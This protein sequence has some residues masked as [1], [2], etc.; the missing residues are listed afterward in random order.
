MS[1]D[2]KALL[3]AQNDFHGRMSRSV[4]NLRKMGVS[5]ITAEAVQARL[6]ILDTLWTKFEAHHDLIRTTLKDKYLES[7]YA[8]ADFIDIAES[9]YVSQRSILVE[10][11]NSL[12]DEASITPKTERQ[13]Q[14]LKTSLPR[15]KLQSFSGA[16]GD[17]PAFR[18]I[19][20]S[21]VGSNASISDVEKLHYLRTSLQGPAEKLIRSLP[22]VGGNYER[23]WSILSSHYENKRELIRANFA[24]F[25]A[26]AKMKAATAD[27]L[28]RVYNAATTAINAQESIARPIDT[29]GMDLFNYLLIERFDAQTRMQ[30][31][32]SIRDSVDPPS[33]DVL[34]DFIAK[35]ILTLNAVQPATVAKSGEASRSAK[36]HFV[37]R[38]SDSSVCAVC[39]E[40]HSVM[41]CATFKA[42]TATERKTLVEA[43]KLCFNCLGNHFLAKCQST[44]TCFTCKARHHT[45]LHDAYSQADGAA[46]LSATHFASDRKAILLATARVTIKDHLGRPHDVRALIDQGS[47]VSLV[48]EALAQRLRLPRDR[49]S[50]K[51]AGIGG[52]TGATR[53]R[54]SMTL[55]SPITGAAFPPIHNTLTEI[56]IL[57]GADAYSAIL[58]D[59]LRKGRKDEPIAQRT[60][61]GWI[62]SGGHR[63]TKQAGHTAHQCTVDHELNDLVKL[64]WEQE[65][66]PVAP[67]AL[68]PEEKRCEDIFAREHSRTNAGRYMV[69]LPFAG[70][71]PSL[72][73]TRRPAERLLHAMER[74]C[75]KDA[76][77]GNLYR[78]FM[79]DYEDLQHMEAVTSSSQREDTA[80]CYLPHHGVLRET[81]T[82][83][84]LRV[85]FNGSQLTTLGTSLNAS[86]LTGANL[87]PA[88][89]DVLLRWRWH[90]YVFVADIEKMYRQILIHQDDR[91]HQRILWR[92]SAADDIREYRLRTVTYGLACAP[93]LAIRTLHQL[94]DDEGTRFPRGAAAL[95]RDTYVDDIVTGAG[96]LSEATLAQRELR[97]LCMAGGFPLRK[98]ATNDLR[99]LD[100]VPHEHRLTHSPHSWFHESHTTLGLHWHPAGDHFTFSQQARHFDELTKRRVLSETARMFDPLGWLTPVTMRAK[101]LIQS[102]WL[103]KLD[104][105]APLPSTDALAWK[106]LLTQLPRLN[107][108]RVSRW[109][110][111]DGSHSHVDLHGFA[112]ASE[113]GY[114]A[115][116]YLRS[117]TQKGT[118]IHLLNAKGKVA[119][120]KPVSLPRLELCAAALL[121]NL[122]AHTR[123]LLSLSAAPVFLWSDSKVTLHWIHGHASRWKTYVAN[124][125][126]LIQEQLPEARWRHVP[127]RDNPADCAS[128]GI[129]PDDL[130]DHLLWWTGPSWL[131]EDEARWPSDDG[132][133]LDADLPERR[134]VASLAAAVKDV[135]ESAF[136]LRFS[137]LHRLL[138]VTAWC[139]RWRR[140]DTRRPRGTTD[141]ARSLEACEIETALTRW[142]HTTQALHFH[143]EFNAL[144]KERALPPRSP[145]TSLNPFIDDSGVMRVGGRLK[146]AML[147]HDE[148]HPIIIP[149]ESR[150]TH[151]M[152]DS[153]H[154]RTLHGGVQLTLG[155]L[156][157]RVW[158]LRGRAVVK[159]VIHRCVTCT[160][161]KAAAPQPMMGNLPR[162]RVT[163]ARPFLRTGVD[164]AGPIF[165]RT[166][167]GRG[168]KA[169]KGFI[170]VFVCLSTKAVHLEAVTD[171]SAE[172]FLAAFRRFV[173]RRGLCHEIFSDC[174][175]NFVGADRELRELFRASSSDGRRI[176]LA[177]TSDGVRWRFNPP[178]AP[179]FGGL[180]EAAVKSTK[181]HLRRVIGEATLTYEEM[182]TLLAQV[183]ACLNSRPLQPLTDDPD[184][185]TALTPGHFLIGAPLLAVPEPPLTAEKDTALS[186]WRLLQKMRDHFWERWSREYLGT[187][188]A[189]PKW[190][191]D[192]TGPSIGD[193]CLLR[194]EITPPT[195]WPLARITALHPGDD[196]IT[197]VV[198]LRTATSK[199]T[200]PLAKIVLLPG[201]DTAA[202]T[203]PV[204]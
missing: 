179:H 53:G 59:G 177:T 123:T 146:H 84:K 152:V 10:Y 32:S 166:S 98:W 83:T 140:N 50:M 31:E 148:R 161:W 204:S 68:T 134:A 62:L 15:I 162:E 128:R 67:V 45:M 178:A 127:G 181:H 180:W 173:S 77:F 41:Q 194:S 203:T 185:V 102:A 198:T 109:L 57:L 64:F 76:R 118:T 175:T 74:R 30:W 70:T 139:L 88:L 103:Q 58:Q 81:S 47:E 149:P 131:L 56:E 136:L 163:P 197:R 7:E 8:K 110:G 44:K 85:V 40:K 169:S 201:A 164:Y 65:K 160:R 22:I 107:E 60:S 200:R 124:R 111:S 78:S 172:A 46:S 71:A 112:D 115:V 69:R 23:A 72:P 27:E 120:V 119:P 39:K 17:W 182:A 4:D 156:R 86:L 101:I 126:S 157:Q 19:F 108:I 99:I 145:L 35:Q 90:R 37:K 9:T 129:L 51:I 63:A 141:T 96:T 190:T 104:W 113:R 137:S 49:S 38:A 42:K 54:L 25:N 80:R 93:F 89:A 130:A 48:T 106:S 192:E 196:G 36:S 135:S 193:L 158:I 95:R 188:A 13:E 202:P 24:A 186:R 26:V 171:Y 183:E 165:I 151:L 187:L 170:S 1:A 199:F 73:E 167:K 52:A 21:I 117:S 114:A 143:D 28:S 16:Y 154:R 105:D 191:R 176:A 94:A 29:H 159:R 43:H 100:G 147:S 2:L 97:G 79:K 184:D 132:A 3:E 20:Q 11:A 150:L 138:R 195:R 55:S 82:T 133:L 18:D 189:R 34:M 144:R 87:L 6:R 75:E 121:T 174:G 155:L 153:C 12:K 92:H 91:D 116:V 66:E 5:S 168:H 14:T 33:N 125:V 61:L 142:I 122:V